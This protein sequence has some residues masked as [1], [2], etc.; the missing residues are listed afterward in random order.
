VQKIND[1]NYLYGRCK[2]PRKVDTCM[3]TMHGGT[4]DK[5]FTVFTKVYVI[6][7]MIWRSFAVNEFWAL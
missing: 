7:A 4:M 3:K 2:G 5:G 6:T 1:E